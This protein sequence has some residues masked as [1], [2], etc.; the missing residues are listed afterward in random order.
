PMVAIPITNDQPGVAA[1]V[2]WSGAGEVITLK[3]LTVSKLR[4]TIRRVLVMQ[5]YRNNAVRLQ[6]AMRTAGGVNRAADVIEQVIAAGQ[7]V[8]VQIQASESFA[9][10]N[11]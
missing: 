6:K 4:S 11:G 3:D 8:S 2:A 5:S 1:R 7:A 10:S 9:M